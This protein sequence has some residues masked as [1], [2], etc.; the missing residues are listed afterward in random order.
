MRVK[1][2][3][4]LHG[5]AKPLF[6]RKPVFTISAFLFALLAVSF[7]G[8]IEAQTPR[9]APLMTRW[10]K[11]VDPTNPLPEYPRP[12]LVREA[13]LNLNGSWQLQS[14]LPGDPVP[15]GKKLSGR[16]I[17]PFPV[18]SALSGVMLHF[19]RLWYRRTFGV[20]SAW[21][22]K[23]IILHF[24]A[25][26]YEAEVYINGKSIGVHKG[27]YDPFSF[28][29]TPYLIPGDAQEIIVRVYDPT[30]S[31]GQPRGKQSTN[32]QY[33]MY[34]STTGIWQTVW[35]EPVDSSHIEALKI[36]PDIDRSELHL[37]VASSNQLSPSPLRIVVK[38]GDRVVK[39]FNEPSDQEL[40]L[41]IPNEKLW[42]PDDPFLYDLEVSLI[43]NG[44]SKDKVTSYF[45]MRKIEVG[46][47]GGSE[48]ILLNGNPTFQMG[49]LDQGFWPDGIY[50]APTDAAL[51]NDI[52]M[53]KAMGFNMVRKHVKVEPARW[54]Y[55]ADKLGILVWQ[56]MPS[57]DSY[58]F[59][60]P[61]YAVPPVDKVEFESELKRMIETHWNSPSIILWT[62]F[63]EGQG[64]FDTQRLVSMVKK[65]DPSRLVNEASGN[66]I[67]GAGDINDLHKYPEPGVR[68]PTPHQ[69][70][71]AG[72]YGG[73][74]YP[75][76]G[77]V[78][79]KGGGYTNVST[80]ND[81][82]YLYA[83]YSKSIEAMNK[84]KALSAVVYTQLTDVMMELNGLLTYDRIP[85]INPALIKLA[86]QFSLPMPRYST[87]VPTSQPMSQTWKYNFEQ[88]VPEN[89]AATDFDDS[90]WNE[91]PAGFGSPTDLASAGEPNGTKWTTHEIW[92]RHH[93]N[94]GALTPDQ[95]VNLVTRDRHDGD[96]QIYIN[97]TLAYEQQHSSDGWEHRSMTSLARSAV[98]V[99]SMNVLAI[100]CVS[101]GKNQFVDAGIDVRETSY[102]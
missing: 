91:G 50:T 4:V 53:M 98:K 78:W 82:L 88:H 28:D 95:I 61:A 81:L 40:T 45:G 34:T 9:T 86:N 84:E 92:L 23:R 5:I 79:E 74:G 26:D 10:A 83:E 1:Q 76:P 60:Q 15:F 41:A 94:P 14:G 25:V 99:N 64:Q 22:G 97:G 18:E 100:H 52:E 66:D 54:Y 63:N 38:S 102:Q 57:A 93:F 12:Q 16:I 75:V 58:L 31:G 13:W 44:M 21:S 59:L 71:V 77:H 70:L 46:L 39:V 11:D 69:A 87:V 68:A 32:P 67:T 96:I 73:I 90:A 6:A 27:G 49:V 72:E 85:K 35:L 8:M 19:D 36:V 101:R 62:L 2:D 42:S 47:S 80:P 48:R 17:V 7:G 20:P 29:I 89:W 33:I 24:G 65:L 43:Q 56:D 55:W 3:A 51:K 30:D 37:T